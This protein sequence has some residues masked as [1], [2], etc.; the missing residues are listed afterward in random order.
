M[1]FSDINDFHDYIELTD[2]WIDLP[3]GQRILVMGKGSVGM[4][5]DCLHVPS[6][7]RNII[8]EGY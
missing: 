4:F 1:M 7:S 8:S 3:S 2:T 6:I 5:P